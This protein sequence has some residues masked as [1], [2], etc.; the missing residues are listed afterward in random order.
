MRRKKLSEQT[1]NTYSNLLNIVKTKTKLCLSEITDVYLKK[2]DK[3]DTSTITYN[4]KVRK[5]SL[6]HYH[7][8]NMEKLGMVK[9][10]L[11]D[12]E[13]FALGRRIYWVI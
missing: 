11:V 5:I 9:S 2:I 12:K 4:D 1:K 7:L 6:I 13:S 3:V 10:E 8:K